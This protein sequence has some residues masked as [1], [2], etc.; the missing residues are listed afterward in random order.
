MALYSWRRA[1][2]PT[3]TWAS[4]EPPVQRTG[5][6]PPLLDIATAVAGTVIV[7]LGTYGEAH[8]THQD[9]YFTGGYHLPHT[10]TAAFLLVLVAGLAL[11]WRHSFPLQVLGV[12]AGSR[13]SRSV[14]LGWVN[15]AM[16][17]LPAAAIWGRSA[18]MRP[19]RSGSPSPG[20]LPSPWY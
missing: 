14:L 18:M 10:P 17:V 20:R 19:G 12:S 5:L 13:S 11:V 9:H 6:R 4:P 8:P 15:G 16:L 1:W 2:L 3:P 7:L